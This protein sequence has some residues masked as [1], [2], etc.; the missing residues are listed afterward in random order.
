M[1]VEH[2]E[3]LLA[4]RMRMAGRIAARRLVFYGGDDGDYPLIS[5]AI[6]AETVGAVEF[7]ERLRLAMAHVTLLGALIDKLPQLVAGREADSPLRIDDPYAHHARFVGE[8]IDSMVQGI[9]IV[10]QHVVRHAALDRVAQSVG[11]R[12]R[13]RLQMMPVQA[14]I[15]EPQHAKGKHQRRNQQ[16]NELGADVAAQPIAGGRS[17]LRFRWSS[18]SQFCHCRAAAGPAFSSPAGLRLASGTRSFFMRIRF[19][20]R[21]W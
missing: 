18:A 6:E 10:A 9:T 12:Q 2:S 21:H 11:I 8:G 20:L 14:D 19:N 16:Q 17:V 1:S 7:G 3:H 4:G 15:D 5:R 13:R